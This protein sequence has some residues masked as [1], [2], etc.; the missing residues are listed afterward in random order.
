MANLCD[1]ADTTGVIY[2][3]IVDPHYGAETIPH[4]SR[5]ELAMTTEISPLADQIH[6]QA[7]IA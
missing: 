6:E 1:D 3:Q 5:A 2:G 4:S 7:A